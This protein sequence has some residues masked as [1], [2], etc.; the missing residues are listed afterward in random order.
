MTGDIGCC[1]FLVFMEGPVKCPSL[2]YQTV[3]RDPNSPFSMCH[4]VFLSCT[5]FCSKTHL[6][7][8]SQ[9]LGLKLTIYV[10]GG[11]WVGL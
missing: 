7:S 2:Q 4:T 1:P 11:V 5:V 8:N 3:V 6:L 9:N 10:W